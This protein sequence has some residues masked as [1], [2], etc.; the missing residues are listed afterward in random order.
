[1]IKTIGLM[2]RKEGITPDEFRRHYEDIH[3]PLALNLLPMIKGYV[4]N[5]VV[6]V[7]GGVHPGMDCITEFWF[8]SV[9]DALEVVEFVDSPPG[10]AIREDEQTFIDSSKTISYLVEERVSELKGDGSVAGA[11]AMVK[12]IALLKR[13]GGVSRRA[14]VDHYETVHAP[15][16]I[17]H[18]VG[19]KRYVRN[20]LMIPEQL[21]EPDFDCV[22]ELWYAN[23]EAYEASVAMRATP[24]GRDIRTD[25]DSFLDRSRIHFFLVDE[26]ISR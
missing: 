14:F 19:L 23:R 6:E 4:R 2:C 7:P 22:T 18:S 1:M 16:I 13:K 9:E 8:D 25:E 21:P 10:H 5:H 3:A 24:Q 26:R 17:S 20:H 15:L 12:A 11:R